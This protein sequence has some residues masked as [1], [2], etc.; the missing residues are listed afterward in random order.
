MIK[1]GLGAVGI[2]LA[3]IQISLPLGRRPRPTLLF[4]YVMALA[5]IV[6]MFDLSGRVAH[7]QTD[8]ERIVSRNIRE[9]GA[10]DAS[11]RRDATTALNNFGTNEDQCRAAEQAV[12]ALLK[13]LQDH[14]ASVRTM[15]AMAAGNIHGDLPVSVPLLVAARVIPSGTL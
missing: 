5:F 12:P 13:A 14:D 7:G 15:A 10:K 6:G 4:R 3:A 9:L 2:S 1:A 11:R 8:N